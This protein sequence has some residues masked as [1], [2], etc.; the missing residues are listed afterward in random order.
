MVIAL[1]QSGYLNR[2]PETSYSKAILLRI[3][4]VNVLANFSA[5]FIAGLYFLQAEFKL[6]LFVRDIKQA[7][8]KGF[9]TSN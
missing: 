5:T 3:N 7:T 2:K 4:V 8:E 6:I 9:V 1:E